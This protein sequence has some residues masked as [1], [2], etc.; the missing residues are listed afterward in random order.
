MSELEPPVEDNNPFSDT[1]VKQVQLVV[2]MR[3][4]DVL[5]ALL[6]ESDAEL[7]GQLHALHEQG[8]ILGSLPWLDLSQD[9]TDGQ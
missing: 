9:V 1:N 3:I 8:K 7:A 5:M 2:L 4:Y 6:Q